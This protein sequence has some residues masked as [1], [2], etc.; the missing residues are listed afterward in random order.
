MRPCVGKKERANT[1]FAP[2]KAMKKIKIK[3][4]H[5]PIGRNKEQRETI[6]CLGFRRL[7]QQREMPDNA[8]VRGMIN[9]VQHLVSVV[10][11]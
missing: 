4:V 11:N 3:Y 7:G 2:T 5:S 10:A 6:R 1:W 9:A 8:S